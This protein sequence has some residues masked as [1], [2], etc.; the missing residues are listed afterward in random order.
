MHLD[1]WRKRQLL[2]L[3][4]EER[5]NIIEEH[6]IFNFRWLSI[7]FSFFMLTLQYFMHKSFF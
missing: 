6:N 3:Y 5:F 7:F 1:F 4:C 2:K